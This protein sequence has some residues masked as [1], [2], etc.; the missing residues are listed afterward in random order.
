MICAKLLA[1][2][3][4]RVRI[5]GT[6]SLE[7][8]RIVLS[9]GSEIDVVGKLLCERIEPGETAR[10]MDEYRRIIM[11]KHPSLPT[12]GITAPRYGLRFTP[13]SAWES[14]E[15]PKWWTSYNNVKHPRNTCYSDASLE[16]VLL[17]S[18]GLCAL[19]G[20]L[21]AEFFA[22]KVVQRPLLSFD[23]NYA[24]KTFVLSGKGFKLP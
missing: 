1:L 18:S 3:S 7:F 13:W 5:F 15:N 12:V 16:N 23:D 11:A 19:L 14:G 22:S 10:N 8:V 2:L 20:Y 24:S 4:S 21:Y 6:H 17:S 9:V